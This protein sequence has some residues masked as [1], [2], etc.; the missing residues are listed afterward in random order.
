MNDQMVE[1]DFQIKGESGHFAKK[2][3]TAR[4]VSKGFHITSK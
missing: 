1:S 2:T 3:N 4:Y